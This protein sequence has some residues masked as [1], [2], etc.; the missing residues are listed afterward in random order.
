MGANLLTPSLIVLH[1]PLRAPSTT[2]T[3]LG[4]A[5][6][7]EKTIGLPPLRPLNQG[8]WPEVVGGAVGIAA[9]RTTTPLQTEA[10]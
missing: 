9:L 7:E 3:T 10:E 5:T 8:N 2:I 6:E 1:F 4:G